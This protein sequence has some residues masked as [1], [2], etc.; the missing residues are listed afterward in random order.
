[1]IDKKLSVTATRARVKEII[2]GNKDQLESTMSKVVKSLLVKVD[3]LAVEE[4][5]EVE[6]KTLADCLED[7]LKLIK[8]NLKGEW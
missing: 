4:L 7:K 1:M 5:N 6:L 3:K 2:E 8:K